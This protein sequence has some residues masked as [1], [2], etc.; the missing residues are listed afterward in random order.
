MKKWVMFFCAGFLAV[1]SIAVQARGGPGGPGS[2]PNGDP[3]GTSSQHISNAG[4]K[5]TNGPNAADRDKGRARAEDRKNRH[6]KA[7]AKSGK[8]HHKKKHHRSAKHKTDAGE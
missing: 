8:H 2:G 6:G 7:H 1:V 3:G 4:M 5:N